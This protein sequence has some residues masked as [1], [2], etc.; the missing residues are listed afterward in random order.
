MG[1][2]VQSIHLKVSGSNL[3]GVPFWCSLSLDTFCPE[4][5]KD[6]KCREHLQDLW[7]GIHY[8]HSCSNFF[9]SLIYQSKLRSDQRN[10]YFHIFFHTSQHRWRYITKLPTKLHFVLSKNMKARTDNECVLDSVLIYT[11]LVNF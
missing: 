9:I 2:Y 7:A 6:S 8:G 4:E 5:E 3:Y 1:N 11:N 10:G